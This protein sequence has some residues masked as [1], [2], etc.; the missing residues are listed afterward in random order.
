MSPAP[1]M[2]DVARLAGVSAMTVSGALRRDASVSEQTRARVLEVVDEIGYVPDQAAGAL[3]SGRSGLVAAI[4]PTLTIP[5][6]ANV[7]RGLSDTL[8]QEGIELFLCSSEY[9][10]ERE[11]DIVT[12]VLRRRPE[13]VVL[14]GVGGLN[15]ATR[16][17]AGAGIPV[18]EFLDGPGAPID[19][20]IGLDAKAIGRA[21][22]EYLR[23]KGRRRLCVVTARPDRSARDQLR[24]AG[25]E[26]AAR[27]LGMAEPLVLRHNSPAS[28]SDQGVRAAIEVVER[29]ID[30][31]ALIFMCDYAAMGALSSFRKLGVDVPGDMAVFGFGDCEIASHLN[32]S[33]TTIAF[34]PVGAGVELGKVVLS[35]LDAVKA[36]KSA[37]PYRLTL[38][39][40]LV[41]RESA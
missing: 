14:T 34:S 12:S 36:R 13:A 29:K 39:F 16:L 25:I 20:M 22:V 2:A 3:S 21:T 9:S 26:A 28:P 32:P 1:T 35:A 7:A 41:E 4:M 18:V 37:P 15:K 11:I 17:L 19:H 24:L 5:L 27:E 31:D 23:R 30:V 40:H 33:L 10:S 6:F 38:D 8:H